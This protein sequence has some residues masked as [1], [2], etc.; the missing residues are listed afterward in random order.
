MYWA[1]NHRI[2]L[3]S[4]PEYIHFWNDLYTSNNII[5]EETHCSLKLDFKKVE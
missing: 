2:C 5:K 1:I 3:F 4:F